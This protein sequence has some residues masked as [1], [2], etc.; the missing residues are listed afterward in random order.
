MTHQTTSMKHLPRL[1]I[2]ILISFAIHL[3]SCKKYLDVK[4]DQTLS[5]PE[6]IADLQNLLDNPLLN[7][8][9]RLINN[10]ADEYY[11][12]YS[13]W[14]SRPKLDKESYIWES[15]LN[16]YPDWRDSY[17]SIFY[18]NTVLDNLTDNTSEDSTQKYIKG[19]A[20]FFRSHCFYLLSQLYAPPY[21]EKT[22]GSK[23][24]VPLRLSSNFNETSTRPTVQELYNQMVN[25]LLEAA[26][27]I[28]VKNISTPLLK[29]RPSLPA[30]YALLA[31]LYLLMGNYKKSLEYSTL[32]LNSY[33]VLLDYN[34]SNQIDTSS[35]T[36][37]LQPFNDEMIF[38]TSI[39]NSLNSNTAAKIDST[40]YN[41]YGSNDLRKKVLF[42]KNADGTYRFKGS[43]NGSLVDLFNGIATDEIYLIRAESNARENRLQESLK[44]LNELLSKRY[45]VNHFIPVTTTDPAELLKKIH[46]ERRKEL[47]YRGVRWTDL[48]RLNNE[49]SFA[50]TI[51]RK[52]NSSQYILTADD[53][54]YTLLIPIEVLAIVNLEQNPR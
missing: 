38:Y 10:S 14:A 5:K 34:S 46:L 47:L 18:A 43:Y 19:Q 25:D 54:R 36:S 20:L 15:S 12:D 50:T 17:N 35:S 4:S 32:C 28:K 37:L 29:K 22:A 51:Q 23:L 3:S 8:S 6:T 31:R 33:N 45:R 16:N 48:R 39:A 1:Q 21:S 11:L 49:A 53:K 9:V 24:G 42:R 40:L 30:C 7:R 2:I 44:D 13:T 27:L 52:L 41:F 26:Q